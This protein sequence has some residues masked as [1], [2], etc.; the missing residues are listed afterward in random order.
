M[1]DNEAQQTTTRLRSHPRTWNEN[2]CKIKSMTNSIN[3]MTF[4]IPANGHEVLGVLTSEDDSRIEIVARS[5]QK[6]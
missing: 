5:A 4:L 6:H 2:Y 1:S 3:V